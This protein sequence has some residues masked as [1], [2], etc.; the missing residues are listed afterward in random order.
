[1]S[2]YR[3]IAT[4]TAVIILVNVFCSVVAVVVVAVA[5]R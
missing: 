3:I 2:F 4:T 1:M 5:M